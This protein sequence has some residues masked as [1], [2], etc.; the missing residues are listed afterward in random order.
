MTFPLFFHSFA[1]G[2][3][4]EV[5]IIP[6]AINTFRV[7]LKKSPFFTVSF[8]IELQAP[9]QKRMVSWLTAYGKKE[10][11][12]LDFLPMQILPTFSSHLLGA[13]VEIPFGETR[14]YK[15]LAKAAGSEKAVRVAGS[16]CRKNPFA[17]FVPCHRVIQ[18]SG[19]IGKFAFGNA[20]KECI[21]DFEKN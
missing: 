1:E 20:I 13:L 14:S 5:Q 21:L 9:V 7:S 4:L 16:F 8:F 11:L 6:C 18:A 19:T 15:E 12:P 10:V 2:P 3:P 17:L